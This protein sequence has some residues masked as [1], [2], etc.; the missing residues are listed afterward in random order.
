[1][2]RRKLLILTAA[3]LLTP[4]FSLAQQTPPD[5]KA[6]DTA[7]KAKAYDLLESLATQIST[8]QSPENRARIG[9]NIAWSLWPHDE[10]RARAIFAAVGQDLNLGLQPPD[11]SDPQSSMT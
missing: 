1:M 4:A 7:L 10:K 8:L 3:V 6:R 2:I 5:D 11:R 9:S